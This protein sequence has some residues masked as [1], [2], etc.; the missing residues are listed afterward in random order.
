[1]EI[2]RDRYLAQA[3]VDYKVPRFGENMKNKSDSP[4]CMFDVRKLLSEPEPYK[5]ICNRMAEV[6]QNDCSGSAVVG[7]ATSGIA[8]AAVAGYLT[9]TPV[10]YVRKKK[11]PNVSDLYLEGT[12][13]PDKKIILVDDLLFA[14][15]SKNEAMEILQKEGCIVTDIVVVVDRQIQRKKDGPS[16]DKRWGIKLHSLI[17]M[18][19]VVEFMIENNQITEEQLARLIMDYT[20]FERWDLPD[21]AKG[22]VLDER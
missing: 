22:G 19:E 18:S 3:I 11:E 16:I 7:L 5:Y 14:G 8:W 9:D 13:P 20:Q 10:L 2:V 17:K 6:V 12:L 15:E 4:S 21:F 1:M